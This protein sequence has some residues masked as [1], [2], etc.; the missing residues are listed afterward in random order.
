[1][2]RTREQLHLPTQLTHTHDDETSQT[3]NEGIELPR[4]VDIFLDRGD[5]GVAVLTRLPSSIM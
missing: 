4:R 2:G 5:D 3:L 1:M